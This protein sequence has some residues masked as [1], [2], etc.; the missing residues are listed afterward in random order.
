MEKPFVKSELKEKDDI[1]NNTVY[2]N[3]NIKIYRRKQ[4]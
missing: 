4:R 2:T 1:T 3:T